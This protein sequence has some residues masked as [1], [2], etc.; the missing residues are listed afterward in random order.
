MGGNQTISLIVT[1]E[2]NCKDTS[3]QTIYIT[4]DFTLNINAFNLCSNA[5][6]NLSGE[7]VA[8]VLAPDS[9]SWLFEDGTTA[10]GQNT[11]F[12]FDSG[13]DHNV[14]LTASKNGCVEVH[15]QI[16]RV[17]PA[18]TANFIYSLTSLDDT[19]QFQDISTT[20]GGPAIV[21]WSWTFGDPMSGLENFST[22]QN[23]KHLFSALGDYDVTLVV[24]DANGCSDDTTITLTVNPRPVAGFRWDLSCFGTDVQFVDTSATSRGFITDWFWNFG[25][26]ASGAFNTSTAQNPTHA[27]T[28]PG[29]YDVQLVVKAFGYDTIIQQVEVFEGAVAEYSFNTPCLGEAVNFMDESVAGDAPIESW[30]WDFADGNTSAEQNPSHIYL[31]SG[32]YLVDLTV[33]DTN[34]C[35]TTVTKNVTIWQGPTAKFNYFSACVGSLT[36]FIDKS[37][38]DGADIISWDWSFGDPAS[39][40][41][42]FSTEQNPSHEYSAPGTY[43]VVLIVE[44]AN[45]CTD[46]DTVNI[47][48]EPGPVAD[49]IADSVCFG[50]SMTFIDQSFSV[51]QPITS[52]YWEFGDGTTS[53]FAN[54]NHTY[55]APGNYDVLLVVE[56]AGGCTAEVVKTVKVYYL[57]V[58]NFEWTSGM[59]CENDTTQFTD[60]SAPVG[61][62]TIVS[63]FWQFGDGTTSNEQSPAHYY[64]AAGNY[65]VNLL[66]TDINGCQNSITQIVVVSQ[67]PVSNF[68]FDN[69]DCKDD[70]VAFTS[71]GGDSIPMD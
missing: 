26:P 70:S 66:V 48:V 65:A 43:E 24:T 42:N 71:T 6:T 51:G 53:T 63:W 37:I 2:L 34:G 4:P 1:D 60:L 10:T 61:N 17:E 57:P 29:I 18:P 22:L 56:T 52:W 67:A 11:L 46:H 64:A 9:W 13:G 3:E 33:T 49:F 38:A 28:A 50:E 36:Y 16:L 59:A 27:F 68:I 41:L 15:N 8:P 44:D 25:D 62:A 30:F 19:V 32:N 58:P 40:G 7:V 54:P 39:G 5:T 20:N 21:G 69:S 35:S 47:V 31:F 14:Q 55:T 45:G 12:T 23:P